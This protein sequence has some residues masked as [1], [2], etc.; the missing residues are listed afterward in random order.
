VELQD[1][2]KLNIQ[3]GWEKW[4]GDRENRSQLCFDERLSHCLSHSKKKY[5]ADN[6][7]SF[8]LIE[9][10]LKDALNLAKVP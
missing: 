4:G 10:T 2:L 1:V 6:N 3:E 8:N 9:Y 5:E 7:R